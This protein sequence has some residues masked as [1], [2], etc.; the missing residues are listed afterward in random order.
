MNENYK[1]EYDWDT[2]LTVKICK[3]ATESTNLFL[4]CRVVITVG[5][6]DAICKIYC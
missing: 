6:T 1:P 4:Q 5:G 3:Y 2:K